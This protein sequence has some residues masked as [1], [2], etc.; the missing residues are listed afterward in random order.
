M[1]KKGNK[2]MNKNSY[3]TSERFSSYIERHLQPIKAEKEAYYLSKKCGVSIEDAEE[4]L[5]ARETYYTRPCS[6]REFLMCDE[7]DLIA[8]YLDY[9]PRL[10]MKKISSLLY[11]S[12]MFRCGK[13]DERE[14]YRKHFPSTASFMEITLEKGGEWI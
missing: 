10:T 4:F 3:K 13:N 1:E 14:K 5:S 12:N 7:L 11:H 6:D 8:D 2:T 9:H